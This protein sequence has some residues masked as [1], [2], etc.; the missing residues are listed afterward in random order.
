MWNAQCVYATDKSE[1]YYD[2]SI[3]FYIVCKMFIMFQHEKQKYYK[4]F[5]N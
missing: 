3:E 5:Q 1:R 4:M 2:K